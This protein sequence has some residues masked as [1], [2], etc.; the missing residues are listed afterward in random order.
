MN[1]KA[2]T[3]LSINLIGLLLSQFIPFAQLFGIGPFTF[4]TAIFLEYFGFIYYLFYTSID[5]FL[6]L[7]ILPGIQVFL[8]DLI[9]N[10][11]RSIPNKLLGLPVSIPVNATQLLIV[12]VPIALI[13]RAF[14]LYGIHRALHKVK[15]FERLSLLHSGA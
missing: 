11:E 8:S 7:P 4:L 5:F 10:L 2:I 6:L 3:F 13:Q 9:T 15:L 1:S 12:L 14:I